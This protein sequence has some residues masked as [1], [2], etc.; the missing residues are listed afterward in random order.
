MAVFDMCMSI[1]VHVR[2]WSTAPLISGCEVSKQKQKIVFG[3]DSL[4]KIPRYLAGEN[5]NRK[6]EKSNTRALA[7]ADSQ[8]EKER[9]RHRETDTERNNRQENSR[10]DRGL[11]GVLC[12][13]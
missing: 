7:R 12:A 3:M 5:Q 6:K 2:S 4:G 10:P 11:A 9:E 13:Y 8:R 1:R